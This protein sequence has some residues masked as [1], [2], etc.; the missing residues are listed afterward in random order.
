MVSCGSEQLSADGGDWL[1][2]W[3]SRLMPWC[4]CDR[5]WGY[6]ALICH[7]FPQNERIAQRFVNVKNVIV[8]DV[9]QLLWVWGEQLGCLGVCHLWCT[10]GW[11][12]CIWLWWLYVNYVLPI[13][14]SNCINTVHGHWRPKKALSPTQRQHDRAYERDKPAWQ[15]HMKG[16]SRDYTIHMP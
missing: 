6:G 1:D 9:L 2:V 16:I 15:G 11:L 5:P 4:R 7:L 13:N 12:W 8:V 14:T 3:C 10:T